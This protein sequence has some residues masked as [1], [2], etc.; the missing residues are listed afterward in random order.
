MARYGALVTPV[1]GFAADTVGVFDDNSDIAG[2]T[3]LLSFVTPSASENGPRFAVYPRRW[4]LLFLLALASTNQSCVWMTWSPAEGPVQ[5]LYGWSPTSI[6]LLAAWGPFILMAVGIFTA[7][8]VERVGLRATITIAALLTFLGT[9]V[10]CIT[11]V[12]PYALWLAHLGQILNAIS[13]P[14]VYA[15][16]SK[17]S[18]EWFPPHQRT[19][20]T[21]IAVM[22][23]SFGPGAGD[24]LRAVKLVYDLLVVDFERWMLQTDEVPLERENISFIL[25]Q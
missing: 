20:A 25:V 11:T 18:I 14:L 15:T 10:R 8:L 12:S 22:A 3:P 9:V 13:G 16:P 19:T 2:M 17:L 4:W 24:S 23:N 5:Q 1:T 21:S 6:D 7:D